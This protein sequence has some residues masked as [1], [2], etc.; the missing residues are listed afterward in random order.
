MKKQYY[1]AEE[2]A[3]ALGYGHVESFRRATREGNWLHERLNPVSGADV[4]GFHPNSLAYPV[5]E[6]DGAVRF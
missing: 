5:D 3:T 6:V 1:T 4:E 2:A